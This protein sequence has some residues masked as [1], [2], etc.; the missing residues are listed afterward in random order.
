MRAA[1]QLHVRPWGS[2]CR[3]SSQPLNI[4]I[5]DSKGY[6]HLLQVESSSG[7][8]M[9]KATWK[10]H[11]F[12]AWVAAFNYWQ[13]DIMYSGGCSAGSTPWDPGHIRRGACSGGGS[14]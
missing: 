12:E 14:F 7:S 6:L 5:S 2:L 3:K 4:I 8:L 10:A 11:K 9:K 1:A 13:T